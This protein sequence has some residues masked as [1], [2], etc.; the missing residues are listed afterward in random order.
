VRAAAEGLVPLQPL[1]SAGI[2]PETGA[3]QHDRPLLLIPEAGPNVAIAPG[4]QATTG[5]AEARVGQFLS[6][7]RGVAA[8]V[9]EQCRTTRPVGLPAYLGEG[10]RVRVDSTA[11]APNRR[12]HHCVPQ[13]GPYL[14]ALSRDL[15]SSVASH[16]VDDSTVT[17]PVVTSPV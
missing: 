15:G 9:Y 4:D 7:E 11:A 5:H 17:N 8:A 14:F 3:A 1:T 2:T 12:L 13:A 6:N 10:R 16:C